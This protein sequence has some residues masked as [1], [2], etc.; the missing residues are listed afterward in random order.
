MIL[1]LNFSHPISDEQLT[2]IRRAVDADVTGY[3]I[4]VHDV[5]C[6]MDIEKPF[7]GQV[8]D[9]IDGIGST[10]IE[11]QTYH[12]LVNPPALSSAAV[13]VLAELHGRCGYYPPHIRLKKAKD[14]MPP[15]YVL[16]EVMD[17]TKQRELARQKR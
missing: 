11:W 14:S 2:Q 12:L 17:V 7:A 9:L 13:L 1:L 8:E 16:A 3:D 10:S 4:Y 5:R 6:Q 15:H